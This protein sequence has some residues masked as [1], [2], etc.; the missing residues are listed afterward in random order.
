MLSETGPG[1]GSREGWWPAA[2]KAS[3]VP[4]RVGKNWLTSRWSKRCELA[5]LVYHTVKAAAVKRHLPN[6]CNN[7][8]QCQES[9]AVEIKFQSVCSLWRQLIAHRTN[10]CALH[11]LHGLDAFVLLQCAK[12][13][14]PWT[15]WQPS[16]LLLLTNCQYINPLHSN[17]VFHDSTTFQNRSVQNQHQISTNAGVS[18]LLSLYS[19]FPIIKSAGLYSSGTEVNI[20]DLKLCCQ[21]KRLP[22]IPNNQ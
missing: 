18:W 6:V 7:P 9:M 2:S 1:P 10:I 17:A 11:L 13:F 20:H 12:V 21:A 4:C 22:S 14:L 3:K 8:P 19:L 16:V 5:L 15:T